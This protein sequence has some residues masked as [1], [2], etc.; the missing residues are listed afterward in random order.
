MTWDE[1]REVHASGLVDVESHTYESRYLPEWPAPIPLDGVAPELEAQ[2]RDAAL[3]LLEDL[4]LAK[5][6]L[7]ERSCRG[8]SSSTWLSPRTTALPKVSRQRQQCGYEACHWGLLAGRPVNRLGASP[9]H[10]ARLSHEYLAPPS[11]RPAGHAREPCFEPRTHR[12]FGV[13][14]AEHMM[15]AAK[16]VQS[17]R[18]LVARVLLGVG[19]PLRL[20][21]P[22]RGVFEREI[23]PY[24]T[25]SAEFRRVLFVGCDW[26][27]QRYERLFR[28][29]EYVTIEVDPARRPFGA[30]RHI[31]GSLADLGHH[32]RTR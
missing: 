21:S 12:A 23:L 29:K 3:P 9:L 4:R 26:Y 2:L 13:G 5:A 24:F 19:V 27:T 30:K 6:R 16:H 17:L 25:M 31:V 28:G 15:P 32:V 7:E 20:R 22:D 8:K 10:V 11:R 1:L 14:E 18:W